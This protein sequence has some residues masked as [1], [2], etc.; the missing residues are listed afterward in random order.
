[1]P[2]LRRGKTNANDFDNTPQNLIGGRG[3]EV[4]ECGIGDIEEKGRKAFL[5]A[6]SITLKEE[7]Q[8]LV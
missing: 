7:I 4:G 2:M 6:M 3:A 8:N 1:M 5:K